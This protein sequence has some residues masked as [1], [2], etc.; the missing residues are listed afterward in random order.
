MR[1]RFLMIIGSAFLVLLVRPDTARAQAPAQ[2]RT[3]AGT[4][5]IAVPPACGVVHA[6]DAL[7]EPS[8]QCQNS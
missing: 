1:E 7:V 8:D 2:T 6:R 3:P 5:T 4:S